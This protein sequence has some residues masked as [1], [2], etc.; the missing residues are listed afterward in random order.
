MVR[1]LSAHA[2]GLEMVNAKGKGVRVNPVPVIY[3][4]DGLPCNYSNRC[5]TV[6]CNAIDGLLRTKTFRGEI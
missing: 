6:H 2:R 5:G 1:G 4:P 3:L